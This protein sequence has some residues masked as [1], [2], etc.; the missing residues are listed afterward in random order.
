V[1][2]AGASQRLPLQQFVEA[3]ST[4][5]LAQ[6][7]RRANYDKA[8]R[9]GRITTSMFARPWLVAALLA[10][11][12]AADSLTESGMRGFGGKRTREVDGAG[13]WGVM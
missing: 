8:R 5:A 4:R 11:D 12:T 10:G 1:A 6:Q 7:L 3:L 2:A 9:L 13:N